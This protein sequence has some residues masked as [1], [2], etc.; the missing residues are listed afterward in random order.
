[1]EEDDFRTLEKYL[2]AKHVM[3]AESKGVFL[4]RRHKLYENEFFTFVFDDSTLLQV[5]AAIA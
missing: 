5:S 4:I 2:N 3:Y 1:M